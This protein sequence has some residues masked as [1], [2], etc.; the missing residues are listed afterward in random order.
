MKIL[1]AEDDIKDQA[2]AL[3]QPEVITQTRGLTGDKPISDYI[4]IIEKPNNQNLFDLSLIEE[5]DDNEYLSDILAIFLKNTP[6]ELNELKRGCISNQFEAVYK[7]AHKLKSSAGLLQANH[8]LNA[9]IKIEETAKAEKN[10]ELPKLA[11]L[12]N[13][14]YK[15]IEI[16]LKKHLRNIQAELRVTV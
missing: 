14:E 15:K 3:P 8:L 9:L 2:N 10:Y 5:M 4:G 12:A 6:N 1:V 7:M 16:P 13:D 11:E